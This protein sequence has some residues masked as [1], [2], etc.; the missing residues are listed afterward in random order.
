MTEF[1]DYAT[2]NRFALFP[3]R[4]GT[5]DP[6]KDWEWTTDVSTDPT[7]W[8][9]WTA[10]GSNLAINAGK[11]RLIVVD[12]DVKEI[13]RER[14]WTLWCEWCTDRGLNPAD[15]PVHVQ[16][17]SQGWHIYFQLP[18]TVDPQ[19][20]SQRKLVKRTEGSRNAIVET[21]A[22]NGYVVA[23]GGHYDGG[24]G[25]VAGTYTLLS[26]AAPYI[27]PDALI[28]ACAIVPP[29]DK[30]LACEPSVGSGTFDLADISG[31]IDFLID[32]G[33]F[34]DEETWVKSVRAIRHGFGD[35]GWPLAERISYADDQNRLDGVWARQETNTT[36]PST[37][38]TIIAES[39]DRGYRQ[40]RRDHMFDGI[41]AGEIPSPPLAP[42]GPL[43]AG[44][45]MPGPCEIEDEAEP[46]ALAMFT[47]ASLHGLPIPV[48]KWHVRDWLPGE[49]VSLLYGDGGVGKSLLALQLLVSTAIGRPWLGRLVE[50]GTCLFVTAEDSKQEVHMRLADVA[51]ENSVPLSAIGDLQ[52]VSLAG[53]DAILAAPDGRSTIL[54]T[55]ALFELLETQLMALRPKLVVLDTLADLFG[56]NEVDRSQARQF[57]G[58]MRGWA[59]RYDSTVLLLA[60][61]SVAGMAKGTGSSG[62]TGWSNSV[63]SRLYFDRIRADDNSEPDPDARV[64][65]SMK[66]NYGRVGDE[67]MVRYRSG[68]FV[69]DL[70]TTSAGDPV[71]TAAKADRVFVE[72]LRKYID[73]NRYVSASEGK[74]F[75]PF[76]FA[77]DGALQGVNKRSL[78]DAMERLLASGKIENAPYGAPSK[79]M[80]RL[81]VASA[82]PANALLTPANG[83]PTV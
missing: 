7:T 17:C 53:E 32:Q 68:V 55:T 41:L 66:S 81:Y 4:R 44:M 3:L 50:Q 75:A 82:P 22:A 1:T 28:E 27:A 72:L 79:K 37:C 59:L 8:T 33:Y 23:P 39:N 5:K 38:A 6:F 34:D 11:S 43:P 12:I 61:P 42:T 31:R 64:L 18:A 71:T 52:I 60:H 13:G 25:G 74:S 48:R 70:V 56:G 76:I 14:A 62:S 36:N 57:I 40:W 45:P 69:P 58:L 63:R 51:R 65:R 47:A 16:T 77:K 10:K 67:I 19:A 20:L 24:R 54:L 30:G 9:D 73:Q 21:R 78:K 2:R 29:A 80:F 26:D 46:R 35:E 49:T 83:V 15:Y